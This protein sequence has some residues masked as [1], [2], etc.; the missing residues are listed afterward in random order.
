MI[1]RFKFSPN[2]RIVV[3]TGAGISA[4]SG[5]KTFR[6]SDGLWENHRVEEVATPEA[7]LRNPELVWRFYKQRYLQLSEVEPN[8]GHKAL[9]QIEDFAGGNF[10]L[11]TQNVDGLHRR[12]G[13]KRVLEI[14]GSLELSFCSKCLAKF[15]MNEIDLEQSLPRCD[16]CGGLLRP[17]I[18]WFGEIPYHLDIISDI[19][20]QA[21]FFLVVGTSG[22]VYPA[23]QFLHICKSYNAIT[24]G[25][26]L[27]EPKNSYLLDEFHQ[28][29]AGE[30]LPE[31]V[32]IW[33]RGK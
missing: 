1:T 4:E 8:P 27:E 17:D 5:L 22:V 33:T 26:N 29:K 32:R 30:L 13:N 9:K 14:H 23:A 21:D 3:L 25:I 11:I 19:L 18:I 10:T 6:D 16:N 24:I 15:P 20:C 31:L 7:Y 12:C 2:D 28:G